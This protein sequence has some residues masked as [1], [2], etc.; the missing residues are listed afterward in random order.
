[1]DADEAAV[2]IGLADARGGGVEG[3]AVAS[4]ALAEGLLGVL[5][6]RD[7]ADE[8]AHADGAA[9]GVSLDACLVEHPEDAA[10]R[11]DYAELCG[12]RRTGA[13]GGLDSAA[14]VLGVVR[15]DGGEEGVLGG[16]TL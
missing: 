6:G 1:V 11:P 15:V 2:G 10:V 4:L 14:Y 16:G 9:G 3:G 8:A 13:Q 12:V 7:V 5:A